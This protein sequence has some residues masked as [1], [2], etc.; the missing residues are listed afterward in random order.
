M[1]KTLVVNSYP[2]V[3]M[4]TISRPQFSQSPPLGHTLGQPILGHKGHKISQYVPLNKPSKN[5]QTLLEL[6]EDRPIRVVQGYSEMETEE[7]PP[8]GPDQDLQHAAES[9][10]DSVKLTKDDSYDASSS[11]DSGLTAK[12]EA[13]SASILAMAQNPSVRKKVGTKVKPPNKS[14]HFRIGKVKKK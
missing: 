10:F 6:P 5:I 4:K 8:K 13:G 7:K 3:M 14:N 9:Y 2:T 1:P 11:S 12:N